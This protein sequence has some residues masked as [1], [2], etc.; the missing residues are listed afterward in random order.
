MKKTF[1]LIFLA[2]M[3][4]LVV[5]CSDTNNNNVSVE[6]TKKTATEQTNNIITE[7]QEVVNGTEIELKKINGTAVVPEEFYIIGED[8]TITE[9]MCFDIGVEADNLRKAIPMLQGQI[10]IVPKN[11]PYS[12]SLHYYI[13][14]KDKSYE[15]ITM[16]DLSDAECSAA[17]SIVVSS[18]G[19]NDY[20]IVERNGLCFFAFNADQGLGNVCRYATIIDGHMIYVY[21]NTAPDGATEE[22]KAVLEKIAFSIRY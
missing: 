18:F 8:Y 7:A 22:Q 4:V 6:T 21:S 15:D 1:I 13:K 2:L 5:A 20:E 10:L 11:E 16:S 9:Q 19:V 12:S 17:A 14:V 3:L